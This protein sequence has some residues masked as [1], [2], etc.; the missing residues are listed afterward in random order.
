[1]GHSSARLTV[2]AIALSAC[3]GLVIANCPNEA[4]L[5][6]CTCDHFGINCMRAQSATHLKQAFR[7]STPATRDHKQLWIQKTPITTFPKDVLGRFRFSEVHIELNPNLTSFSLDALTNSN[8]LLTILSLYGNALATFEFSKLRRFPNL[9]ALNLAENRL[10]RIPDNAFASA[11][12]Q[13]LYLSNNPITSIGTGAFFHL[14]GLREL[15]LENTR[16]VT[17][18]G[19]SLSLP[20]AHPELRIDLSDGRLRQIDPRAFDGSA[21]LVLDLYGNNLTTLEQQPFEDLMYRMYNGAQQQLPLIQVGGN[22]LT[23]R[24]CSYEWLIPHS[25]NRA[26]QQIFYGF[27]CPDG[28]GL[29]SITATKIACRKSWWPFASIG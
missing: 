5:Q 28:R 23:C 9:A 15:G 19:F 27:Q 29:S 22:P 7:N 11:K 14:V 1:M 3:M 8:L 18:Q 10:T 13:K 2:A 16:L 6:P 24:G 17:L 26:V 25:Q 21:P 12:L 20:Q 4:S